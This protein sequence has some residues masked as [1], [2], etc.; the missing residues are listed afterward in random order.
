MSKS[1]R[2][3]VAL[4]RP[5]FVPANSASLVIGI[6][7]GLALPIDVVWG[8]IVPAVLAFATI[9]LVAAFAAH[10]NTLSDYELDVEDETKRELVEAMNQFGR[11]RLRQFMVVELSVSLVLLLLLVVLEA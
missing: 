8:L 10:I 6:S 4:G 1:V 5:E 3:V 7:W 9:T 2:L 11:R